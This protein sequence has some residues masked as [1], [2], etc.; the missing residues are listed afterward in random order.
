MP[1]DRTMT[2][3][4]RVLAA[5]DRQPVDRIPTDIWA[6]GEVMRQLVDRWGI[7]SKAMDYGESVYL[8]QSHCPLAHHRPLIETRTAR[9]ATGTTPPS[10]GS[11]P[12]C[13]SRAR[14]TRR[15]GCTTRSMARPWCSK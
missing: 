14:P 3:R 1:Q 4:Q 12:A 8:E 7:R 11:G 2:A 10:V 5:L 15:C 13:R 9:R 6:I